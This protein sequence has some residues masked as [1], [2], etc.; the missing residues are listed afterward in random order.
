MEGPGDAVGV[1]LENVEEVDRHL[2]HGS[3]RGEEKLNH[4]AGTADEE[5]YLLGLAHQADH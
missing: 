5:N 1:G 3:Q 2:Q 4:D